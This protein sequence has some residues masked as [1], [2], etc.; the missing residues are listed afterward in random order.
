MKKL[1]HV[2]IMVADSNPAGSGCFGWIRTRFLKWGRIRTL[3]FKWNFYCSI[4]EF[5]KVTFTSFKLMI[6]FFR[7]SDPVILFGSGYGFLS[8][9]SD[10]DPVFS[11]GSDSDM[12]PAKTHPVPQ[13]WLKMLKS[14]GKKLGRIRIRFFSNV[15]PGSVFYEFDTIVGIKF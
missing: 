15:G 2:E 9:R 7:G 6:R 14:Q 4:I 10:P 8:R 13:P 1:Q 3:F 5:L 12:D 11:W